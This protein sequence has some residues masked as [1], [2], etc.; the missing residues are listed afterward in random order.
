MTLQ[1]LTKE[2]CTY[3]LWANH[4]LINRI[5]AK[6]ITLSPETI[7]P[8][9]SGI[10]EKLSHLLADEAAWMKK[11]Q[12]TEAEE[13][14]ESV[15]E[16][17]IDALLKDLVIQSESFLNYVSELSEVNLKEKVSFE[18]Q[19][20]GDFEMSRYEMIQYTIGHNTLQRGE[21]VTMVI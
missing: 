15:T 21:I 13:I 3:N 8:S 14:T 4:Q 17:A 9:F 20:S 19:G 10:S 18:I 7:S 12:Q 6:K 2:L 5:T 16:G 1:T 11:M